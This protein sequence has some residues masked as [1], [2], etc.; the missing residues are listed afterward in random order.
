RQPGVIT[1]VRR[2]V[3][4]GDTQVWLEAGEI[5]GLASAD[6]TQLVPSR[7][8]VVWTS[9][10]ADD[11]LEETLRRVNPRRMVWVGQG[12]GLFTT[13]EFLTRLAGLVKFAL[14]TKNGSLSLE[15]LAAV[16]GQRVETVIA[17]LEYLLGGG[18]VS[19][20]HASEEGWQVSA[21][22]TPDKEI[23]T[24]SRARVAD[25][26]AETGSYRQFLQHA[27]LAKLVNMPAAAKK[28]R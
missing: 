15:K 11:V 20:A 22:G 4:E 27:D 13:D 28:V 23:Q 3:E 26:M 16:T 10:A 2:L 9:P 6:R 14:R 5:A 21:G 25:L 12:A 8:L 24:L 19:L 17:G 1:V 7:T 18:W